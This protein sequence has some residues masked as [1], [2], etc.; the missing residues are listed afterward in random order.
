MKRTTIQNFQ[1][2]DSFALVMYLDQRYIQNRNDHSI[3]NTILNGK[4]SVAI[5]I[6]FGCFQRI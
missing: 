4:I 6:H 1:G 3:F 5:G 2:H